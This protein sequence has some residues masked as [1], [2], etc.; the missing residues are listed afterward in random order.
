VHVRW[1]P[2]SWVDW[3]QR[4]LV[5]LL[6]ARRDR[7]TDSYSPGKVAIPTE[8]STIAGP[9]RTLWRWYGGAGR[10]GRTRPRDP[11]LGLSIGCRM[12][13]RAERRLSGNPRSNTNYAVELAPDS[14][15]RRGCCVFRRPTVHRVLWTVARQHSGFPQQLPCPRLF[16]TCGKNSPVGLFGL[17]SENKLWVS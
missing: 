15:K 11:A 13:S 3:F 9:A 12:F 10:W 2:L 6:S 5:G 17:S 4:P 8:V 14:S 7:T 1:R 16:H